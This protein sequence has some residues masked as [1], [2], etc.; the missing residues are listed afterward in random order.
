MLASAAVWAFLQFALLG[1]LPFFGYWIYQRRR[2]KRTFRE[3]ARRA[4]LQI[5]APRY[6]VY[7]LVLSL[8]GIALG[9]LWPPPLAPLIRPG[10]TYRDFVGL[11]FNLSSVTAAL[12]YGVVKTGLTEEVLF[13]GLIAGSLSR[14]FPVIWANVMQ[15]C[16]FLLPH[17][18][19]LWIAPELWGFL[20][21]VFAVMLFLGWIRIKSG[22]ILGSWLMHASG[23]VTMALIVAV[24]TAP[25][26]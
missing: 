26:A 2:Y 24:R 4:G 13:R 9:A 6:L 23:N 16:I 20:P 8:G 5:G 15:A 21:P 18:A 19:V 10:S 1:G 14:R 25:G 11:G 17:L 22:S 3:V 12:L 7:S